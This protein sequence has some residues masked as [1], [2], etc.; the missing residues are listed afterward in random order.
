MPKGGGQK[1]QSSFRYPSPSRSFAQ[2]AGQ[3]PQFSLSFENHSQMPFPQQSAEITLVAPPML[4][5]KTN[6][7]GIITCNLFST[8][9]HSSAF[10]FYNFLIKPTGCY[11]KLSILPPYNHR[12]YHL[13]YYNKL[14]P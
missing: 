3:L 13:H 4:N 10:L 1:F 7:T 8:P 5:K 12:N 11:L 2:S 9:R 6:N 14:S